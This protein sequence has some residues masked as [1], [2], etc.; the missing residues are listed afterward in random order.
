MKQQRHESRCRA[1]LT[2]AA[3]PVVLLAANTCGQTPTG[4]TS[5]PFTSSFGLPPPAPGPAPP[6]P[7][8]VLVSGIV[9]NDGTPLAAARVEVRG[10]RWRLDAFADALGRYRVELDTT[11]TLPGRVWVTAYDQH[12]AYQPCAVWF[13]FG[14]GDSGERIADVGLTASPGVSSGSLAPVDFRTVL[15]TVYA[16]G[17]EGRQPVSGAWVVFDLSSDDVQARARTDADGR[18][19]LCG[20]PVDQQLQIHAHLPFGPQGWVVLAPGG[21]ADVDVFLR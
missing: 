5:A 3:L 12:F 19:V 7:G 20:L 21:D 4:P 10:P 2:V 17:S 9:S 18:F 6:A 8:N 15:G 14:A 1:V 11:T 13:D 16:L